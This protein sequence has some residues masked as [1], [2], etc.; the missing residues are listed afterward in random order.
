M[1]NTSLT[2]VWAAVF[3]PR[4]LRIVWPEIAK[5]LMTKIYHDSAKVCLARP[6]KDVSGLNDEICV[7]TT[8][9]QT[10]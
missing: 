3:V 7:P 6:E 8:A 2:S 10:L 5:H 9:T 4:I 1:T